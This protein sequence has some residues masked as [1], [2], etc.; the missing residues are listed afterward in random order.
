LAKRTRLTPKQRQFI[1]DAFIYTHKRANVETS[2][3]GIAFAV[4]MLRVGHSG[5]YSSLAVAREFLVKMG[6]IEEIKTAVFD[7]P[8]YRITEKGIQRINF[9]IL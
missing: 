4:R 2:F 6:Y 3:S 1:L 7:G 8:L 9:S 5:D